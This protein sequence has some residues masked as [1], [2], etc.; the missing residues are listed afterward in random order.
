ML[1]AAMY[2]KRATVHTTLNTIPIQLVFGRDTN[3]NI[4]FE[5]DWQ[6][7]KKR[8][9]KLIKKNNT[10]ENKKRIPHIYKIGNKILIK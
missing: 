3:L 5:T 4:Q 1:A 2:A 7:I 9:N 8:K 10:A 6:L